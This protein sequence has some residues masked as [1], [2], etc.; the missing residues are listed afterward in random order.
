VLLKDESINT[1]DDVLHIR[2]VPTFGGRI[3]PRHSELLLSYLTVPY[4]RIPLVLQFFADPTRIS[5]LASDALQVQRSFQGFCKGLHV[6]FYGFRV[7][8]IL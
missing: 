2:E 6:F 4:L 1:E 7:F 3:S 5:A 8:V